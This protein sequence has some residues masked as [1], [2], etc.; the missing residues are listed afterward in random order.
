MYTYLISISAFKK[1][2][3]LD[4]KIHKDDHQKWR[5]SLSI[6]TLTNTKKLL[7]INVTLILNLEFKSR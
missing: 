7:V 1:L 3:R 5:G 4:L 2:D 6:G